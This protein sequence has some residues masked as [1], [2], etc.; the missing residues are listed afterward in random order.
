MHLTVTTEDKQIYLETSDKKYPDR[1]CHII[2]DQA[3]WN[4]IDKDIHAIQY[5]SDGLKEIEYKVSSGKGNVPITDVSTLQIYIDKFNEVEQVFQWD[6]NNVVITLADG[7]KRLETQEEKI[8]R[9]GP[10][11]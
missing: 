6:N 9:I 10:R 2:D 8:A 11:P 3:F 5:H 7:T 1:R 4:S